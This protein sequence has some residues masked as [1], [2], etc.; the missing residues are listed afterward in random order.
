MAFDAKLFADWNLRAH[1]HLREMLRRDNFSRAT[2]NLAPA[3]ASAVSELA[4]LIKKVSEGML[5]RIPENEIARI[6]KLV[7]PSVDPRTTL[8]LNLVKRLREFPPSLSYYVTG[9]EIGRAHV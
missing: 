9:E 8:L 4:N 6:T 1:L 3:W 2:P 7:N 5:N